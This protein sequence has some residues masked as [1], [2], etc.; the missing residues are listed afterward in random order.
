[1]KK[2]F[3]YIDKG[4][5][6][7]WGGIT[8]NP[9]LRKTKDCLLFHPYSL[10]CDKMV[11]NGKEYIG[12][13]TIN[14]K[15]VEAGFYSMILDDPS[16]HIDHIG[17]DAH[18]NVS[19][20][21]YYMDIPLYIPVTNIAGIGNT[22][23]G[24][25]SALTIN[26]NTKIVNNYSCMLGLYSSVLDESHISTVEGRES[27]SSCRFLILKSEESIQKDLPNEFSCYTDI[28]LDNNR[29]K[30]LFSKSVMI[31]WY[32]DRSLINDI[33]F[34]RF[35]NAIDKI[36]WNSVVLNEVSQTLSSFT[37]PILGVSVR[38][39]TAPHERNINRPYSVNVYKDA[40]QSVVDFKEVNSIFISYDNTDVSRDYDSFLRNYSVITYSKPEYISQ[41]QYSVIKM[42]LLSK[43][44][45][46][47][48]NRISTFSELVF[49]FSRCSQEVIVLH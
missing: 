20:I 22:L 47:V 36:K 26:E 35:M 37:Y 38:S 3:S 44:N 40:I 5:K 31:D 13:Y 11:S 14:K 33:V 8:F 49:W 10:H 2:D 25:I 29:L 24:F 7:T 6:Y 39:W 4:I 28:D 19:G 34:N 48:C 21:K 32:Y 17:W 1:M 9:G 41:L 12:E 42:L 30:P 23:K 15:Y 16:G 27:F 45:Y 43:C 18:I 46:F